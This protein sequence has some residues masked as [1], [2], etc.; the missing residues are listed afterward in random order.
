MM[1]KAF[2]S[3]LH[4]TSSGCVVEDAVE[5][6][7][8]NSECESRFTTTLGEPYPNFMTFSMNW[9]NN[10]TTVSILK[11]LLSIPEQFSLGDLYECSR[12]ERYGLRGLIVFCQNHYFAYIYQKST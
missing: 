5:D 10:P 1:L 11:L 6:E 3:Q 7:T 12:D 4:Q 9:Q 2:Q 8:N